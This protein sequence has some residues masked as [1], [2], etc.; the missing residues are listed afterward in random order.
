MLD[1]MKSSFKWLQLI[2]KLL[3]QS[4][5]LSPIFQ[6]LTNIYI[7]ILYNIQLKCALIPKRYNNAII[8][9]GIVIG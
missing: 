4:V 1:K 9:S 2:N 5:I 8:V 3:M 6:I 7:Y